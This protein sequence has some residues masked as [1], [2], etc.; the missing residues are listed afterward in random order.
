MINKNTDVISPC[1]GD[2]VI[3]PCEVLSWGLDNLFNHTNVFI[4][5]IFVFS[6]TENNTASNSKNIASTK[7]FNAI[8]ILYQMLEEKYPKGSYF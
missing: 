2:H 3:Y 8:S 7:Y 4:F 6:I 5:V 1:E